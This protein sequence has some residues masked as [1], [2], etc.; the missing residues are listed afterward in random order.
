MPKAA[1]QAPLTD[2]FLLQPWRNLAS[3]NGT[4][5][6]EGLAPAASCACYS[7]A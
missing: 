7:Q 3:S 5:Q 2:S 1:G 6:E 4:S